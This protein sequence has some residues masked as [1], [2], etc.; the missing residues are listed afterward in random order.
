MARQRVRPDGSSP[1]PSSIE[2]PEGIQDARLD[3]AIAEWHAALDDES[4]SYESQ[5]ATARACGKVWAIRAELL[6][7]QEQ[8]DSARK[9]AS[10][11]AEQMSLASKLDSAALVDRVA[12]LERILSQSRKD[13]TALARLK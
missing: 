12:V 5:A 6:A 2:E 3:A 1:A 9:A 10:T 13:A 11:S 4:N 8:H 7:Q